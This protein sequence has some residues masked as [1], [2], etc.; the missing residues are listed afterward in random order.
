MIGGPIFRRK[1]AKLRRDPGRF[2]LDAGRSSRTFD[3]GNKREMRFM[4]ERAVP[5]VRLAS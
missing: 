1:L 4:G 2:L 5:L 3:G